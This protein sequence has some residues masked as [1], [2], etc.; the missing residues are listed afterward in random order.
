MPKIRPLN[1]LQAKQSLANRLAP[2]IDRIRQLSTN[3]GIRP[4]RVFLTWT[5]WTGEVRGEGEELLAKQ[6]E[7]LPTPKVDSLDRVSFSLFAAGTLPVGSIQVSEISAAAFTEDVLTGR[8]VPV[9]G[10]DEVPPPYEF[11]YEVVEDG[12]GDPDPVRNRF[13]LLTKPFRRAGKVDWT[14]MLE[15]EDADRDRDDRSAFAL[16]GRR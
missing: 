1:P 13:R 4:Y 2:T 16:P 15:K 12:R 14:I 3:L 6:V 7:I 10:E 9:L 5:R 11:F 8:A